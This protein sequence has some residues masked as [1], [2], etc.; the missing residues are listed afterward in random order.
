M[1]TLRPPMAVEHRRVRGKLLLLGGEPVGLDEEELGAEKPDAVGAVRE[2][3]L[4]L[5]GD[6]DIRL[7]GESLPVQASPRAGRAVPSA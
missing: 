6:L 5:L 2:D 7:H 1:V 3:G 4:R